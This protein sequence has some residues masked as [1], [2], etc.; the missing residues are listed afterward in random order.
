[1]KVIIKKNNTTSN[2]VFDVVKE[3]KMLLLKDKDDNYILIN[4]QWCKKV[5]YI[6]PICKHDVYKM[7]NVING[8]L[9]FCNNKNGSH[10]FNNDDGL[11]IKGICNIKEV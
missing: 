2:K 10:Y 3:I 8:Q 6:C 9:Y 11:I 5:K 1:M 4:K 7:T